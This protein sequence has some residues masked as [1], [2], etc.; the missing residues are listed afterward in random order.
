MKSVGHKLTV[1]CYTESIAIEIMK[2]HGTIALTAAIANLRISIA[3]EHV[4]V[5]LRN[6]LLISWV[7]AIGRLPLVL[8]SSLEKG[9]PGL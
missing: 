3:N 8:P 1:S 6:Y 7:V 2:E 5:A 9:V 4:L